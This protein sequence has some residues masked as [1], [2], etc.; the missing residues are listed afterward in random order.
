MEWTDIGL[1]LSA[2]RHGETAAIVQL[3]T[4]DHGRHAGLVAGGAGKAKR[5][6][7][8]PGTLLAARWRARLEEHLGSY[9]VEPM[10]ALGAAFLT[11]ADRLAALNAVCALAET[12][13]PER[14]PH[15][16][17]F[18]ATESLLRT[19][20]AADWRGLYVRW[21]VA[22]LAALGFGLDLSACAATGTNDDLVYVSPKSGRAVSASAGEP[23]RDKLLPLPRFLLTGAAATADEAGQGLRLTGHFL[24]EHVLEPQ[25]RTMPPARERLA[26]RIAGR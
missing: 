3:L 17:L 20:G 15:P 5:A 6:V 1:V 10:A 2:R 13:L 12:V 8:Q 21:E 24:A 22:L 9:T 7:L 14:D 16:A 26:R 25:G 19:L 11:D 23:Y 18:E 4:R